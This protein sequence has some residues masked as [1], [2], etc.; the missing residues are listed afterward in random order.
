MGFFKATKGAKMSK[1]V[2]F[3]YTLRD[4]ANKELLE[5]NVGAGELAFVSGKSQVLPK[6]EDELLAMKEGESKEI[7]IACADALGEYSQNM[8]QHL[9]REQFAGIDL[10]V[11]MELFGEDA[12]GQTAR[13]VVKEITDESVVVDFNHPYSGKDLLFEVELTE[14]RDADGDEELTGV[15]V[16]P[17][18][19]GCGGHDDGC[20]G[21]AH[22]DE[23]GGGCCGKHH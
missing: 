9:P 20:C 8:I 16:M 23:N 12:S 11:G 6:L 4:A 1:V 14:L 19:C 2:K 13:V 22:H 18:T 7:F 10:S 21:G 5:T 3:F 17:H 15:V